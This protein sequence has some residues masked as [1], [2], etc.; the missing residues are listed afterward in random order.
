MKD[1]LRHPWLVDY[2]PYYGPSNWED[3]EP[4]YMPQDEPN[5]A[6]SDSDSHTPRAKRSNRSTTKTPGKTRARTKSRA[7][8]VRAPR[9][10]APLSPLREVYNTDADGDREMRP[11]TPSRMRTRSRA[12]QE[13]AGMG[14]GKREKKPSWKI[15]EMRR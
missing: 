15:L 10:R 4:T 3:D 2:A 8:V 12:Y 11:G 5:A 9:Q 7:A 6:T 1:V 14:R 13:N